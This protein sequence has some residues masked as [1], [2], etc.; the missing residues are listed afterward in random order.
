MHFKKEGLSIPT[1][2]VTAFAEEEKR[3]ID[4]LFRIPACGMLKK[5]FDPKD[6]IDAIDR[7]KGSKI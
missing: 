1:I 7:L 6:L 2:I 4:E 3:T 5:P